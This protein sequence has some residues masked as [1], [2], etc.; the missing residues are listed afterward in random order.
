MVAAIVTHSLATFDE[1]V[2][3]YNL[4][5][6]KMILWK[7]DFATVTNTESKLFNSLGDNI[8]KDLAARAT[9]DI[10]KTLSEWYFDECGNDLSLVD[11][12]SLGTVFESS[13]EL[14]FYNIAQCFLEF[15]FLVENYDYVYVDSAFDPV[16]EFVADWFKLNV[17]ADIKVLESRKKASNSSE[18]TIH[19]MT[20]LRDLKYNFSGSWIDTLIGRIVKL[21]QPLQRKTIFILD[22]G[23]F[24]GYLSR[25]SVDKPK[26]FSILTPV[27]RNFKA[28][29]GNTFFWQRSKVTKSFSQVEVALRQSNEYG[30][31]I[32]SS[33]IPL[34][35]LRSGLQCFIFGHWSS[36]FS[37]FCYYQEI[38]RS[39]K[40]KLAVFCSE[41]TE[42]SLVG[43]YA[44]KSLGLPSVVM[45]HGVA[46]WSHHS[47]INR[48]TK[49]F[50]KYC[51]IGLYDSQKYLD[52]GLSDKDILDIH[53][54][55]F[56]EKKFV[57][58]SRK[59]SQKFKRKA[60]LLPLDTGYSL[61]ISASS[62]VRHIKEMIE[63]CDFCDIEIFGIKFRSEWEVDA[64][65]L[66][67]GEN[68]IF[69]R[70]ILVHAG[71]GALSDYFSDI[72]MVIGP[73]T[74]GT[75]ECAL[76][77]I[78]YF[79]FQDHSIYSNNPNVLYES[80]ETIC[81]IASTSV[82]LRENILNRNL[83]LD[84]YNS[85]SLVSTKE[86]YLAACAE[87]DKVFGKYI[88]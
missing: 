52:C 77:N 1:I 32:K 36:A 15:K 11:G 25:R 60:M 26:N 23:K 6:A 4:K 17:S 13:T 29:L 46:P 80:A 55:W 67:V 7:P 76:A 5:H 12:C 63:V 47:L 84:G 75:A 41:G 50:D 71:Y 28:S 81:H 49:L 19:P 53:F 62:I 69:G 56:S 45:A 70:K 33:V 31:K 20:Q 18:I 48:P 30:W 74:S 51:S 37:Y 65:G 59:I 22:S 44:A 14:L 2:S 34:D 40:V 16:K 88:N 8:S 42:M 9:E 61:C 73:F 54:P 58:R 79:C 35:I 3:S 10:H 38:F 72:D 66:V 86:E 78:D 39:F 64:Y 68:N 21:V 24:E 27:R 85:Q 87:L 83:F 43:A 82:E 57:S